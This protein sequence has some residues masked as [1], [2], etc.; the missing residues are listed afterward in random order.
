VLPVFADDVWR[1][2]S[3]GYGGLLAAGG[4]G[5]LI[6]AFGLSS[7]AQIRRQG[8][9]LIGS[10][11]LFCIALTAFAW[12]SN[13]W[14]G[15]ALLVVV[16]VAATVFTTMIATII[17]LRVPGE[18][19]GRVMSLYT[20]TLIGLP[21]LGSLGVAAVARALSNGAGQAGGA[22]RAIMLG[23]SVLAVVLVVTA[24]A[25]L[26]IRAGVSAPSEQREERAAPASST[27]RVG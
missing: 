11:L 5:A 24:P 8:L 12:S 23:T 20:I 25:L 3:R 9:V 10:G 18:L 21:A 15:A 2:G 4:A 19:R 7:A 13:F 27:E 22:P 16:G 26:R 14:L 17:Q 6:G 1:V